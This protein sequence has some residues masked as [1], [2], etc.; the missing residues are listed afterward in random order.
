MWTKT[1]RGEATM[2]I[3][4]LNG[5]NLNLLGKRE[6]GI[7]GRAGL[8]EIMGAARKKG[9]ELGVVVEAFQSN[10]EGALITRIGGSAGTYGGIILNP[11]GYTHTSVALRD[12]VAACGVPCVEVHLSN[13]HAR[14]DFR[15]TSLTAGV[16]LGQVMG[17]GGAGYELALE[18]LVGWLRS[19]NKVASKRGRR[20]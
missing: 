5:P 11:A 8:E 9:R 2:K 7:Y 20:R 18:G 19:G 13:I 6:P 10:D 3:L 17:F 12:A 14:E 16:C 15:H 4:I 1:G